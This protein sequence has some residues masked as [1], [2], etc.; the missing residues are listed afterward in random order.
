MVTATTFEAVVDRLQ[1]MVSRKLAGYVSCANAYST[2]LAQSDENLRTIFNN[3]YM[4]TADGVPVVW[5]I[6]LFGTYAERVHNDD[7]VLECCMRFPEWKYFLVGG[8]EGQAEIVAAELERRFPGIL[9]LGAESTPQLPIPEDIS[10]TIVSRI[11]TAQ[12]DV[13]WVGMGTPAQDLWMSKV[14]EEV[15]VPMVGCGSL[16]DL[17]CG[18]TRVAPQWIKR[19]GLQWLFRLLQE[20]RRLFRRYAYHNTRFVIGVARQLFSRNQN[21]G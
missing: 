14:V 7:L 10:K 12:P 5:A 17:L 3:S 16:F 18:N 2:S 15:K 13:V 4:T 20:P 19:S 6:K 1:D 21:T 8:A 11:V 9:I